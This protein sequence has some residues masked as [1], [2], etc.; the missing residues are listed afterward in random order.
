MHAPGGTT[1][2]FNAGTISADECLS[3]TPGTLFSFAD[4]TSPLIQRPKSHVN[5]SARMEPT[6][7]RSSKRALQH[8]KYNQRLRRLLASRR[9]QL[10]HRKPIP[11]RI[12]LRPA[13]HI[14]DS[15][16]TTS[17][18]HRAKHSKILQHLC[19]RNVRPPFPP[20]RCFIRRPSL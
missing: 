17:F 4:V 6:V 14:R 8:N 5:N 10:R 9:C 2:I 18:R 19:L 3:Q 20:D 11:R 16:I 12:R 15:S 1:R 7:L 13:A